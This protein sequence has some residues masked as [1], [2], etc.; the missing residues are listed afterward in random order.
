MIK[1]GC[2]VSCN[3]NDM[4]LGSVKEAISYGANTFMFYLGAPQ[5][6]YRKPLETFLIEEAKAL[7]IE[8]NIDIKDLVVHAP[9]IVNLA[10]PDDE[11][12][13]FAIEFLSS[14]V[15]KCS[16][17][18]VRTI[19]IHPGAAVG[20]EM[21][22]ALDKIAQSLKEILKNTNDCDVTIAIETMAGKGTECCY[23]FEQIKILLDSVNSDRIKVCYD[24][25][26]TSDSGY[27][28]KNDYEKVISEFDRI[29]GTEKIAV[30][31]VNDSKNECGERKDRHENIGFG[32]I[33]FDALV[34]IIYD[35]RFKDIP[36]IL[37]TPYVKEE[38]KEF[39]PYKFEIAMIKE[40]KFD[41][42]LI[43][44]IINQ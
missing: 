35:E 2:H 40:K 33:G 34:K 19:V 42:K 32:K 31:H 13:N 23:T 18:G 16:I 25:C 11:K 26:H 17:I 14:E 27:D 3:G 5:N 38:D 36:K 43:E 10:Q 7:M 4:F 28:L 20:Q 37:E 6:T 44:K 1:I 39:P 21:S 15:K 8:N 12:R 9:Y 24:T 30:I 41:E 29:I 22:I